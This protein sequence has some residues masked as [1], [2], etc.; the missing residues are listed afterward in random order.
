MTG[1]NDYPLAKLMEETNNCRYFQ[2]EGWEETQEILE[3]LN[4]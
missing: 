1:G 3:S 4:D 2:T